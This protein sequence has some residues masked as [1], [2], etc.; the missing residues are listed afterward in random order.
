MPEYFNTNDLLLGI[1]MS[2]NRTDLN[3]STSTGVFDIFA[4]NAGLSSMNRAREQLQEE[5]NYL[6]N[7]RKMI[8]DAAVEA[9]A[10][11][12]EA[13][14]EAVTAVPVNTPIGVS[15]TGGPV[16]EEEVITV[17]TDVDLTPQQTFEGLEEE[18]KIKR[19]NDAL[20][21]NPNA[22]LANILDILTRWN[23][24]TDLFRKATGTTPEEYVAQRDGT[25]G[26]GGEEGQGD[27]GGKDRKS[28]V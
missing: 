28:V 20:E 27:D 18:Q 7:I 24:P 1:G 10:T 13:Q 6:N 2:P 21:N 22:T 9:G 16:E 19:I 25:G 11:P 23:I 14:K 15:S 17:E 26:T 3:D 5:L 12:Q 8:R 4:T